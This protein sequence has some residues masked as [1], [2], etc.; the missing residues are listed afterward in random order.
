MCDFSFLWGCKY[1]PEYLLSNPKKVIKQVQREVENSTQI[2]RN[3]FAGSHNN[4]F[5]KT[6][7]GEKYIQVLC[8]ANISETI[9]KKKSFTWHIPLLTL[10]HFHM[11][12]ISLHT[13]LFDFWFNMKGFLNILCAHAWLSGSK[14]LLSAGM[15]S[16]TFSSTKHTLVS[17]YRYKLPY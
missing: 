7:E 9:A 10:R 15:C 14:R 12:V 17:F 8:H 13:F 16:H 3:T 4:T 11:N 1:N 5:V 2:F 6:T